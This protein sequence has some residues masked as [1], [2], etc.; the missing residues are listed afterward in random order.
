MN[1]LEQKITNLKQKYEKLI[2]KKEELIKSENKSGKLKNKIEEA[3][4][5]FKQ[6][7]NETNRLRSLIKT[8]EEQVE[9]EI[10]QSKLRGEQIISPEKQK[11]E[12]EMANEILQRII[13]FKFDSIEPKEEDVISLQ[14]KI[15]TLLIDN[16][17]K[18]S[19]L[20]S[21]KNSVQNIR[22][23]IKD[24]SNEKLLYLMKEKKEKNFHLKKL[25]FDK[26]NR[27]KHKE[28]RGFFAIQEKVIAL[29]IQLAEKMNE[30]RSLR[31]EYKELRLA[32]FQNSPQSTNT[33]N[34]DD[35]TS[36]I[37]DFS[38]FDDLTLEEFKRSAKY[39]E[40]SMTVSPLLSRD[41]STLKETLT[42]IDRNIDTSSLKG[43]SL[44][45]TSS[46]SNPTLNLNSNQ[47][48]NSISNLN[49]TKNHSL[50]ENE[51]PIQA[52]N[53]IQIPNQIQIKI[54]N[55]YKNQSK[56]QNQIYSQTESESESLISPRRSESE[57]TDFENLSDIFKVPFAVDFFKEFLRQQYNQENIMFYLEILDF[58]K[59]TDN[60]KL[61]RQ[62]R[63]IYEKFVKTNSIF[64]INIDSKTRNEI[65]EKVEKKEF[66]R[67]MFDRAQRIIFTL[68]DQNSFDSFKYSPL[69][70]DLMT[71]LSAGRNYGLFSS[72]K[73]ATLSFTPPNL[74][75]LNMGHKFQGKPRNPN[76]LSEFLITC[77]IDLC[78]SYVSVTNNRI[79][80]ELISNSIPFRRFV[81]FTS[82][83]QKI[84]MKELKTTPM[85]KAFFLNIYNCLYLH[86]LIT[87]G[88]P[89]DRSSYK[90]FL[91]GSKYQIQGIEF[92]LNDI[93]NGI[94]RGN[95]DKKGRENK[96]IKPNDRKFKN[97]IAPD[98]LLH[99]GVLSFIDSGLPL[100]VFYPEA[101][102]QELKYLAHSFITQKIE[103]DHEKFQVTLPYLFNIYSR[104]FG[105]SSQQILSLLL[106]FLVNV[107]KS[108]F[109]H[110][111]DFSI[112]YQTPPKIAL[113][114][115]SRYSSFNDPK[116]LN[117]K[118]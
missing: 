78:N 47:N 105:E 52:P 71:R 10:K 61:E 21:L 2:E 88:I 113:I 35:N 110:L 99:F 80:T 59:Q 117:E 3:Q 96:Y 97:I 106:N 8:L 54:P 94:L 53:P 73:Q 29:R 76:I 18:N 57:V 36:E 104:D 72:V 19:L 50:N 65:S 82:E 49:P 66:S 56:S 46:L 90:K 22:K 48:S 111:A 95:R 20:I 62:A 12:L 98:F 16:F 33:G 64:E 101:L 34:D 5:E 68:M 1:Q 93:F 26:N 39:F 32:R 81:L 43:I 85:K 25:L 60:N 7:T 103:I 83:L 9:E 69:Y 14:E 24:K 86:A 30:N 38:D 44:R 107:E 13:D 63:N 84:K 41:Q 27:L 40:R 6:T 102:E 89:Q 67:E 77:L 115:D 51:N 70:Q 87:K 108:F 11:Q 92:S 112:K 17:N 15:K 37:S 109:L 31:N 58:Q 23:D 118:Y 100:R 114:I 55:Q 75:S 4:N 45:R 116:N 74:S 91:Y 79:E 28:S 42:N